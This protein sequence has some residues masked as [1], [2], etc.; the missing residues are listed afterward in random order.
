MSQFLLLGLSPCP[1]SCGEDGAEERV[2][3][4]AL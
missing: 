1:G 4:G 2:L 3:V